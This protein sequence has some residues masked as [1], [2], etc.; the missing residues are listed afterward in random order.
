MEGARSLSYIRRRPFIPPFTAMPFQPIEELN[1]FKGPRNLFR[2]FFEFE[3]GVEDGITI[4]GRTGGSGPPLL[5]LHGWSPHPLAIAS[6]L[7]AD[8]RQD[9][10]RLISYG[11]SSRSASLV[12]STSWLST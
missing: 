1:L 11:T 9:F 8:R 7:I 3:N 5:L 6:S 10:H 2:G 4:F 12:H